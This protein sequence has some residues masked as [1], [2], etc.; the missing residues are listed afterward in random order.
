MC[1]ESDK[2]NIDLIF[3]RQEKYSSGWRGAPAKGIDRLRGAR[4][5]IPPSP[6]LFFWKK[7]KISVD[8]THAMWYISLAV[9]K[10]LQKKF[11][12]TSKKFLTIVNSYDIVNKLFREN[13]T[14]ENL[15]NWTVKHINTILENSLIRQSGK[16][17]TFKE[18]SKDPLKQ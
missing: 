14:S 10:E 12:K 5:Q 11:W 9:A 3:R 18:R 8:I 15:D 1:H 16:T 7:W 17:D 6:F 13:S 2:L 4:V